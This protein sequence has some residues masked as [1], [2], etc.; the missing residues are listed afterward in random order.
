MPSMQVRSPSLCSRRLRPAGP[1]RRPGQAVGWMSN[2]DNRYAIHQR[3]WQE[4]AGRKKWVDSRKVK[5]TM[6]LVAWD[7]W[8]LG[9][10]RVQ[11]SNYQSNRTRVLSNPT[12]AASTATH[13]ATT[14]SSVT[15]VWLVI[16]AKNY[17]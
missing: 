11:V 3:R 5:G 2:A 13:K 16:V 7:G 9:S 8:S 10:G 12:P 15:L 14:T 6:G 4:S 1:K 17:M